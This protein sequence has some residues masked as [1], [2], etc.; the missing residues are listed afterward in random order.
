MPQQISR[1]LCVGVEMLLPVVL[2]V[3]C[4]AIKDVLVQARSRF[5]KSLKTLVKTV[6]MSIFFFIVQHL[7][8]KSSS[9]CVCC[10]Q[11]KAQCENIWGS[12]MCCPPNHINK[13]PKLFFQTDSIKAKQNKAY[14]L[15]LPDWV[16]V[17]SAWTHPG[18]EAVS[19]VSSEPLTWSMD[20][21]APIRLD[22]P[23]WTQTWLK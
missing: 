12:Q 18:S 8:R 3:V 23:H 6:Q 1:V 15:L 20:H 11:V 7:G 13:T 10:S 16:R 2:Y 5:R 9:S 19:S 22:W 14:V 17:W 4:Q 21:S